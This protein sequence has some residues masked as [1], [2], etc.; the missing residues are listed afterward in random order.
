MWP[1]WIEMG[2]NAFA[3]NRF[4]GTN[5]GGTLMGENARFDG[6][7]CI[8]VGF[9]LVG[10]LVSAI[11]LRGGVSLYN[12]LVGGAKSPRAV[13]EPDMARALFI[14]FVTSITNAAVGF[15]VGLVAGSLAAGAGMREGAYGGTAQLVALLLGLPITVGLLSLLL[16]TTLVRAMLVTLCQLL[17]LLL[18]AGFVVLALVIVGQLS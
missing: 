3:V 17:L 2:R 18:I 11:V 12:K 1:L 8:W 6:V 10:T 7:L 9:L 4:R 5:I 15:L 16:P 14:A 13:P